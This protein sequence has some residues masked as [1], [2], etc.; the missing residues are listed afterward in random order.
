MPVSLAASHPC[1]GQCQLPQ[2]SRSLLSGR[3]PSLPPPALKAALSSPVPGQPSLQWLL[4][5]T[6]AL[7]SSRQPQPCGCWCWRVCLVGAWVQA[8]PS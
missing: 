6:V 1:P 4:L 3:G 8:D 2:A 5:V 7:G